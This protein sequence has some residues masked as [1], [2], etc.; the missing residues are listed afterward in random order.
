MV[1]ETA[2]YKKNKFKVKDLE[3]VISIRCGVS[4]DG[5]KDKKNRRKYYN[6]VAHLYDLPKKS[7]LSDYLR[8]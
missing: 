3:D 5:V 8:V 2:S 4:C 6:L 1:E 7:I